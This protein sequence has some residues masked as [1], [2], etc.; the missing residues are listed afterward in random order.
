LFL[1]DRLLPLQRHESENILSYDQLLQEIAKKCVDFSGAALAGVARAAASHALE[2][3]V[4]NF[5]DHVNGNG[6]SES[7]VSIMD[8]LVTPD[9]FFEAIIDVTNSMGT[10]DHSDDNVDE[11]DA[12]SGSP[13]TS[14]DDK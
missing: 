12:T 14:D 4:N 11:A 13:T 3:A 2:R 6:A 1:I 7:T 5:S 10:S 8:C 9:D